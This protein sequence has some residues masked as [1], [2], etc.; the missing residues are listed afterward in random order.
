VPPDPRSAVGEKA[1][2]KYFSAI[3]RATEIQNPNQVTPS[4]TLAFTAQADH[5]NDPSRCILLAKLISIRRLAEKFDVVVLG[6]G[7][8]RASARPVSLNLIVGGATAT[9]VAYGSFASF[10]LS[11]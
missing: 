10:R 4:A 9:N 3:E 5:R 11:D 6:A 1:S 8:R 2:Q 7:A